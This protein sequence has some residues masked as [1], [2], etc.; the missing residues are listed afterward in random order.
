MPNGPEGEEAG[1]LKRGGREGHADRPKKTDPGSMPLKVILRA[2]DDIDIEFIVSWRNDP[3]TRA[4]SRRQHE[5]T[6]GDLINAP[7][8]GR[9]ETLIAEQGKTRV[10]YVHLDRLDGSCEL[11]WVV[12]PAYRRKGI[13]TLIVEAAVAIAGCD[14][15]T[16][17]IRPRNEASIRIAK[18]CGFVLVESHPDLLFWRWRASRS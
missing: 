4:Q 16:A 3:E 7:N 11:S 10:G 18:R 17:E 1:G 6:W 14:D 5:L 13:G 2:V 8:G 12:A 15:V 9:R